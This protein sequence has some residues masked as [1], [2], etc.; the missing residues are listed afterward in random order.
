[1][2]R[3]RVQDE[4]LD[5]LRRLPPVPRRTL[6]SAIRNLAREKGDIR[7]LTEE[8]DGFYRLRVGTYRVLFVYETIDGERCITCVFAGRRRWIYEVFQ[9]KLME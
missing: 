7:A 2:I 3:V 6:R 9:S 5:Y 4:V 1:M 8:L